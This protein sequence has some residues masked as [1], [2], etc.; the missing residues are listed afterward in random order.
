MSLA[1]IMMLAPTAS[2][3]LRT[4]ERIRRLTAHS[5]RLL[6]VIVLSRPRLVPSY[7]SFMHLGR[8]RRVRWQL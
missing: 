5:R 4:L 8:L 7:E 2:P 1:L 3:P 6:T